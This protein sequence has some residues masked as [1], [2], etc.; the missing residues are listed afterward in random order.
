MLQA[1]LS[2]AEHHCAQ[3]IHIRGH[4]MRRGNASTYDNDDQLM[5]MRSGEMLRLRDR[6]RPGE[7]LTRSGGMLLLRDRYTERVPERLRD[8]YRDPAGG[9]RDLEVLFPRLGLPDGLL[10]PAAL[11]GLPL[12]L[13]SVLLLILPLLS[14][15]LLPSMASSN[16]L[17][18]GPIS[19]SSSKTSRLVSRGRMRSHT[20]SSFSN[21]STNSSMNVSV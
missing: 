14:R 7:P 2:T 19:P 12:L 8:I 3:R 18:L 10:A 15:S 9:E 13:L 1:T 4:D 20:R 6:K 17:F 5:S 21:W 11:R 16:R